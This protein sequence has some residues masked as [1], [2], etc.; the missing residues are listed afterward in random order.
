MSAGSILRV[1]G[2]VLGLV[3]I[4]PG[5]L[6]VG[7]FLSTTTSLWINGSTPIFAVIG[8]AILG[9]LLILISLRGS[10]QRAA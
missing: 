8:A 5:V 9:L 3:L 10:R 4:A 2:V 7:I 1:L 6:L